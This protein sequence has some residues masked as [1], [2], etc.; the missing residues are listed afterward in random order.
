MKPPPSNVASAAIRRK[1]N[2]REFG[3]CGVRRHMAGFVRRIC[4]PILQCA[5]TFFKALPLFRVK[6]IGRSQKLLLLVDALRDGE[7][8]EPSHPDIDA[9]GAAGI[10]AAVG[11]VTG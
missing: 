5:E 10:S 4:R 8:A 1:W 2:Q 7:R 11:G 9:G 3:G 6:T